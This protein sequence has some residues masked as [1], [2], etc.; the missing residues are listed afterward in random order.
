MAQTDAV[1]ILH[2]RYIGDD[3]TRKALIECEREIAALEAENA[4]LKALLPDDLYPGSKDWRES[5]TEGRIEWLIFMYESKKA[6][7]ANLKK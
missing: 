3:K 1:D 6:E 4:K 5:D 2:K 7:N